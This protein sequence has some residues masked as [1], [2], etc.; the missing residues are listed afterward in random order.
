M[1][2]QMRTPHLTSVVGSGERASGRSDEGI[3]LL[4]SNVFKHRNTVP[5][6]PIAKRSQIPDD[7][8][9]TGTHCPGAWKPLSERLC[10]DFSAH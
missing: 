1:A 6:F 3:A 2:L 7:V 4:N 8:A 5:A 10:A 9:G